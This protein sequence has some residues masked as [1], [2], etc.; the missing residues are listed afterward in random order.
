[1]KIHFFLVPLFFC[2]LSWSSTCMPM[3]DDLDLRV[4]EMTLE[5]ELNRD[6]NAYENPLSLVNYQ[7]PRFCSLEYTGLEERV[8]EVEVT[9][10]EYFE[11]GGENELSDTCTLYYTHDKDDNVPTVTYIQC[12]ELHIEEDVWYSP[13]TN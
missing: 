7:N 11:E 8:A 9:V 6:E 13:S 5:N 10:I 3:T 4:L 12:E 1:M 2:Q